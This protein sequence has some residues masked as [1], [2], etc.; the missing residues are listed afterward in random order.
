MYSNFSSI[1]IFTDLISLKEKQMECIGKDHSKN[2]FPVS[3]L[4]YIY[5]FIFKLRQ[6]QI[7]RRDLTELTFQ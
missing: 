4:E 6:R 5:L 1:Q 7:G 2:N 3:L